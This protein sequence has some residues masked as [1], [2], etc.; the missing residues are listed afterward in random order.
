MFVELERVQISASKMKG[1]E[2]LLFQL[3]YLQTQRIVCKW[4]VPDSSSSFIVVEE[5][6]DKWL[7]SNYRTRPLFLNPTHWIFRH[8]QGE[9]K[10]LLKWLIPEFPKCGSIKLHQSSQNSNFPKRFLPTNFPISERFVSTGKLLILSQSTNSPIKFEIALI[11]NSVEYYRLPT[12]RCLVDSGTDFITDL[13]AVNLGLI[14]R[15]MESKTLWLRTICTFVFKIKNL[16]TLN[17]PGWPNC[18][19]LESTTSWTSSD[20][21]RSCQVT[22]VQTSNNCLN[23]GC[24]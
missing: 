7:K 3:N 22:E 4:V 1:V 2:E 23:Y 11:Q 20:R 5:I 9:N 17:P 18:C 16:G 24:R 14:R 13:G 21:E 12:S 8:E 15:C 19:H 6:W 10:L